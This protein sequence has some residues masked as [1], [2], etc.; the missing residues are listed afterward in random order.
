MSD[1][2]WAD[3]VITAVGYNSEHTHIVEVEVRAD[4]GSSLGNSQI[5]KRQRVVDLIKEGKT[6]I[7]ATLSGSQYKRGDNVGIVLFNKTEYI[8]TDGNSRGADNLGNL[9]ELQSA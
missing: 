2:K 8:R 3:Y 4:L 9:P 5:F 6:F 1:A 7:T